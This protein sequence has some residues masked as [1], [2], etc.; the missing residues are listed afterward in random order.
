MNDVIGQR[1]VAAL[2]PISPGWVV[3][4]VAGSRFALPVA[5]VEA[6]VPPPPLA[7]VPHAAPFLLGAGNL[8][9]RIA[10]ILDL[11]RFLERDR[12]PATYDGSGEVLRLRAPGGSVGIW[13][14]RVERLVRLDRSGAATPDGMG[15]GPG[16]IEILDPAPLLEAGLTAP[17][18]AFGMLAPLGDVADRVPPAVSVASAAFI[19]VEI[20][21][22]PMRLRQECVVE[23]LET[24]PWTV[25]PR[26]PAGLLGIALLRGAAVPVLSMAVLAGAVLAGMDQPGPPGEFAAIEIDG[27]RVLRAVDR[28]VGLRVQR[29]SSGRRRA[30]VAPSDE[31]GDESEPID[32]AAMIP[33]ELRRVILG[34]SPGAG[35]SQSQASAVLDRSSEYLAFAVAGQDCAV[36]IACVERVVGARPSIGLPRSPTSRANGAGAQAEGAIELHGRIVP[37]AS[38][39]SRLAPVR[40]KRR[41]GE[42]P[43]DSRAGEDR[44]GD[45]RAG[46]WVPSFYVIL[47][48][49]D[50]LGAIGVDR[51]KGIVRLRPDEFA[52]PP[53]DGL[54]PIAG[55]AALPDGELLRVIAP[56]RLWGGG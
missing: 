8:G 25:L 33:E 20:A 16:G 3:F 22:T 45:S 2:L 27:R 43:G 10:P 6:V 28:I 19:V 18:L 17:G 11:A 13:V 54:G 30:I 37:V 49:A 44:A 9:G 26:A 42:Q 56:E 41:R 40:Y 55:I 48:D 51:I 21:G 34:F 4:T 50:G 46:G 5:A 52:A 32:P 53:V 36:P 7:R 35:A 31:P 14:D 15:E 39:R 24:V 29:A 38:L 23:L 47:R 1:P 12:G